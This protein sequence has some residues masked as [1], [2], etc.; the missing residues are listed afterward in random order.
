MQ[1]G[2]FRRFWGALW[3]P[4]GW[5]PGDVAFGPD[6]VPISTREMDLHHFE[7]EVGAA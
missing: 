1:W 3:S 5:K 7:R 2:A 4:A 6:H